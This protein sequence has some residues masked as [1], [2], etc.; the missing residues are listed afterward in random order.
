[1]LSANI[2]PDRRKTKLL[3]YAACSES[4]LCCG[5]RCYFMWDLRRTKSNLSLGSTFV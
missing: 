4:L 2:R 3:N 5:F 1:V